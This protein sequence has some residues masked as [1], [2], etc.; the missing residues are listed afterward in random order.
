[1]FVEHCEPFLAELHPAL[2]L[3]QQAIRVVDLVRVGFDLAI[4]K[5]NA[6]ENILGRCNAARHESVPVICAGAMRTLRSVTEGRN[7]KEQMQLTR[8]MK[9]ATL[10]VLSFEV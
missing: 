5:S 4:D 9:P 2:L 10:S 6:C 7:Q 3:S 8:Y 1:M